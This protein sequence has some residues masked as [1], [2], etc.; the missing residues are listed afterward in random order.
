MLFMRKNL[1]SY[2]LALFISAVYLSCSKGGDSSNPP[3]SNS[4][5]GVNITVSTASTIGTPCTSPANGSITV[6]ASGSADLTYSI[7]GTNF[8][9]SNVFGSVAPGNYT[10]TAK[11]GN[12][13]RQTANITVAAAPAGALFSAVKQVIQNNC[14]SCHSGSNPAGGRDWT[15]DCNVIAAKGNIKARAVDQAGTATQMPKPPNAP[16]SDADKQKI[17]DWIN[18]GGRYAD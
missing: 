7:D 18:A 5:S 3:P 16:L 8:Q 14:V 2:I 1:L 4:C 13:C 12:G 11:N 6:T 9:S 15:V 10:V 17:V